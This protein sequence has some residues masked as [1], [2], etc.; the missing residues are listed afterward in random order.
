VPFA[1]GTHEP[2]PV[3]RV[4]A[5]T[6]VGRGWVLLEVRVEPVTLEDLFVRAV[7]PPGDGA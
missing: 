6:I 1:V 5:A 2:E 3:Q 7:A 4:L